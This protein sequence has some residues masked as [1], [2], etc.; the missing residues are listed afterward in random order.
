MGNDAHASPAPSPRLD[1]QPASS[2]SLWRAGCGKPVI[3]AHKRVTAGVYVI[4]GTVLNAV[5]G[6]A[7]AWRHCGR[8]GRG[9]QP[10]HCLGCSL[11]TTGAF[12]SAA[13]R[14]QVPADCV[15]ARLFDRA[16]Y[17]EHGQFSSAVVTGEGQDTAQ[18]GFRLAPGAVLRGVVTG[19]GGDPVEGARLMLFAE[20]TG[21]CTWGKDRAGGDCGDRRYWFVRVWQSWQGGIPAGGEGG[22][23]VRDASP[24]AAARCRPS[25]KSRRSMWPIPITYFDSTTDE[26][27]ASPIVLTGGS[28]V[29]ADVSLHA[30]PA[31]HLMVEAPR[32]QDGSAA[33]P[34]LKQTIF[35]TRTS[36]AERGFRG[37][38]HQRAL[39]SLPAW[40]RGSMS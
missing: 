13:G 37:R 11:A 26:A 15:Q 28:R 10:P 18:P 14:G 7:G 8:A 30:V 31:L 2:F 25:G 35:G 27:S 34:E 23:L 24:W 12:R 5:T 3:A 19:D 9:R 4:A 21:S 1:A 40:H 16:F 17:D 32:K 29:E 20:A 36:L 38:D 33:V 39:R 22:A 6:A